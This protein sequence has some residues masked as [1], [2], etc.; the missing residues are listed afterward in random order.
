[1]TH[2]AFSRRSW[3]ILSGMLS[4][5]CMTTPAS[6]RRFCSLF[7]LL[8][9]TAPATSERHAA[10]TKYFFI[11]NLQ[12]QTALLNIRIDFWRK[13]FQCVYSRRGLCVTRL[14][15]G[16]NSRFEKLRSFFCAQENQDNATHQRQA[17]E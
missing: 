12:G 6:S 4:T 1:M 17:S 3:G 9:Y 16:I 10:A 14:S 7:N 8:A 5:S 15:G 2:S 11:I 13:N